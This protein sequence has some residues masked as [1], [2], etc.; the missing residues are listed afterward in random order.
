MAV[1]ATD[2]PAC[3][4]GVDMKPWNGTSERG[5]DEKKQNSG[6]CMQSCF[7]DELFCL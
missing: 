2:A 4:G 5:Y 3:G 7:R 6:C 1:M